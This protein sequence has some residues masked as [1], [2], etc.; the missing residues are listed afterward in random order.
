MNTTISSQRNTSFYSLDI[1]FNHH[2]Y[3]FPF[4]DKKLTL[5]LK[6]SLCLVSTTQIFTFQ[7]LSY[8]VIEL[9]KGGRLFVIMEV[10]FDSYCTL[11]LHLNQSSSCHANRRHVF[12]PQCYTNPQQNYRLYDRMGAQ[13][14][15]PYGLF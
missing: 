3:K 7:I 1:F 5:S 4:T 14:S 10:S 9:N 11:L 6:E 15:L 8:L 12:M 13:K 2:V